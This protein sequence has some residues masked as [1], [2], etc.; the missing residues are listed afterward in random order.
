MA[1]TDKL[2]RLMQSLPQEIF[3]NIYRL[4]F[5]L[6]TFTGLKEAHEIPFTFLHVDYSSREEVAT[7]F[8]STAS[9]IHYLGTPTTYLHFIPRHHRFLIPEVFC[10]WNKFHCTKYEIEHRSMNPAYLPH[11]AIARWHCCIPILKSY[12]TEP[13]LCNLVME[14]ENAELRERKRLAALS[15]WQSDSD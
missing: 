13:K 10:A 15:D 4:T 6:P 2:A 8:Y 3:D 1:D 5:E 11:G 7:R 14:K 9:I 12:Y